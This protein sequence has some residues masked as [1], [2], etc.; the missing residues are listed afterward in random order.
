MPLNFPQ[1]YL[2][3]LMVAL[4]YGS[5]LVIG[6]IW[7][8]LRKK[9]LMRTLLTMAGMILVAPLALMLVFRGGLVVGMFGMEREQTVINGYLGNPARRDVIHG[10]YVGTV[11]RGALD[12]R[13]YQ[14]PSLDGG[15][16][17][18]LEIFVPPDGIHAVGAIRL[19][20]DRS[21]KKQEDA[22]LL[23]WPA[24][25]GTNPAVA[26]EQFFR[27]YFPDQNP[28]EFGR[29]TVILGLRPRQSII[30]HPA[31]SGEGWMWRDATLNLRK[32]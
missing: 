5:P 12:H 19:T 2:Y 26:T 20:A 31:M 28:K 17:Y 23:V 4:L 13:R 1:E 6:G 18:L 25:I 10:A 14:F 30:V 24:H 11:R 29:H 9:C 15:S 7:Y 16:G 3:A 27:E 32:P 21:A 22:R 8:G